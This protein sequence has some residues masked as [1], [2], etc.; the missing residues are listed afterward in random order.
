VVLKK[1][2]KNQF[3]RSGKKSSEVFQRIKDERNII[4]TIK[5][6]K[7]NWIG[8]ILRRNLLLNS[9]LKKKFKGRWKWWGG[10]EEDVRSY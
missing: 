4:H 8:H 6:R 3:N 7:V 9:A 1:D 5:R 10:E 2:G